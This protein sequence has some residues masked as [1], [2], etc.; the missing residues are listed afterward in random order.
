[1]TGNSCNLQ[2]TL[3]S[4]QS[5]SVQGD[6]YSISLPSGSVEV[7]KNNDGQGKLTHLSTSS[8]ELIQGLASLVVYYPELKCI[9]LESPIAEDLDDLVSLNSEGQSILWREVLLQIP[10]Y[11]LKKETRLPFPHKQVLSNQGYHPIRPKPQKGELYRRYI[12]Q[13]QQEIALYGLELEEHL[14]LFHKW[15]NN[16]RV[17]VFWDQADSLEE[18]R[19]YLKDQL[20][21]NKNQLLIAYLNDEPFAYIEAYW[22]K[23]DR[24]APY[25]NAGDYD[26]GIHML[27]GEEKHRGPHKVAAWLPSVCHFLYLSDPRTQ[28]IVSEPRADNQKM[29]HYL[30]TYGFAKLKEFDFPHK[31][32]ALMSQLRD[33]FFSLPF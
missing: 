4:G 21:N 19:G 32:S 29:I 6:V 23:E 31:R 28:R 16:A 27:V 7:H 20:A 24:I 2:N 14:E 13:L 10:S 12:P 25:Y 1:M 8:K 15:Q 11:W 3:P 5:I 26:R 18:H 30:Q 9:L 33:A 22:A 17:A